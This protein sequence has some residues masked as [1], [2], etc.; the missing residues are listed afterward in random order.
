MVFHQT[1]PLPACHLAAFL[2]TN[3]ADASAF[4]RSCHTLVTT[5]FAQWM[6]LCQSVWNAVGTFIQELEIAQSEQDVSPFS[7]ESDMT[8]S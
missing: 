2:E 1:K 5:S 7:K 6:K 4:R 8:Y 3:C